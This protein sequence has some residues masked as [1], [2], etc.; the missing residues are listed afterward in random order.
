MHVLHCIPHSLRWL[1]VANKCI[2]RTHVDQRLLVLLTERS[3]DEL[4]EHG[5]EVGE[6]T[7][8]TAQLLDVTPRDL[9]SHVVVAASIAH[10]RNA[11]AAALTRPI[12]TEPIRTGVA[13]LL[14]EIILKQA[15]SP[16]SE[17]PYADVADADQ[18]VIKVVVTLPTLWEVLQMRIIIGGDCCRK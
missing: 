7:S 6:G 15:Y 9:D 16:D 2:R 3:A 13:V 11:V 4:A 12:I 18:D 5:H 17:R 1:W 10:M 14:P 8:G